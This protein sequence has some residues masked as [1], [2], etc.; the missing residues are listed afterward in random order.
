MN[1]HFTVQSIIECRGKLLKLTQFDGMC[2][3]LD[4]TQDI[5]VCAAQFAGSWT[6]KM[7]KIIYFPCLEKML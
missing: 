5:I 4:R 7:I 1:F 2:T 6:T 3:P